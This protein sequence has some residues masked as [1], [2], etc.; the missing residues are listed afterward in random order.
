[1]EPISFVWSPPTFSVN[2]RVRVV[3]KPDTSGPWSRYHDHVATITDIK[4]LFSGMVDAEAS[5]SDVSLIWHYILVLDDGTERVVD[6]S[7]YAVSL[8][9][10]YGNE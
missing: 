10:V 5:V 9:Y 2:D 3:V 8:E 1:M 4:G 6:D 7:M